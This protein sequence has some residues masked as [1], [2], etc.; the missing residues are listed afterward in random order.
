MLEIF[1]IFASYTVCARRGVG[2]EKLLE[3]HTAP[4]I[5]KR[6]DKGP[7]K[8]LFF[9]SASYFISISFLLSWSQ[10]TQRRDVKGL[11]YISM[12]I[13]CILENRVCR[14]TFQTPLKGIERR[15]LKIKSLRI[16]LIW[17]HCYIYKE[18]FCTVKRHNNQT[19]M[20]KQLYKQ[21]A[22]HSVVFINA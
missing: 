21:N 13:R 4:V 7:E 10:K 3:K 22:V 14:H 8:K 17:V 2:S 9:S 19:H 5:A 6:A 15:L 18:D 16:R 20:A 1:I 12:E 11:L